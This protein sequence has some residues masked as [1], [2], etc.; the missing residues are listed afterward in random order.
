MQALRVP[1][2][3]SPPSAHVK[4]FAISQGANLPAF[5]RYSKRLNDRA[6]P[7]HNKDRNEKNKKT[8]RKRSTDYGELQAPQKSPPY[9]K[10]ELKDI[11]YTVNNKIKKTDGANTPKFIKS[12]ERAKRKGATSGTTKR[13]IADSGTAVPHKEL[14]DSIEQQELNPNKQRWPIIDSI[15]QRMPANNTER[16]QIVTSPEHTVRPKPAFSPNHNV[17]VLNDT[18]RRKPAALPD[19]TELGK[20]VTSPDH[21]ERR[22]PE[23]SPDHA[24]RGK[25]TTPPGHTERRQPTASPENQRTKDGDKRG[26]RSVARGDSRAAAVA[27]AVANCSSSSAYPVWLRRR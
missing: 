1:R 9:K 6:S 8:R 2:T 27:E 12:R 4:R 3:V 5:E 20:P 18:M 13:K 24:E 17:T 7:F 22:K 10:N 14:P 23:T 25:P 15:K 21:A 11:H 16:Q 19:R 26:R